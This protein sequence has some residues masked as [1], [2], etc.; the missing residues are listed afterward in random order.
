MLRR[1]VSTLALMILAG[2]ATGE[3]GTQK[4]VL[5]APGFPGT[6]ESAQ[7]VMDRFARAVASRGGIAEG[8]LDALYLNVETDAIEELSRSDVAVAIVPLAFFVAHERDAGLEPWL[9]VARN[10]RGSETWSLVARQGALSAADDLAEWEIASVAGYSPQFVRGPALGSWGPVPPTTRI[11]FSRSLLKD[12]RRAAADEPVALLLDGAQAA[13]MRAL[14]EAA[15]LEV[16]TVSPPLPDVLVCG[17]RG[18][19]SGDLRRGVVDALLS[20]ADAD[21]ELLAEMRLSRFLPLDLA[22]LQRA[23]QLASEVIE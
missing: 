15:Q 4:I 22:A 2:S 23:R 17:V 13:A 6:T 1:I 12:I 3:A 5:C 7:P 18:R 20:L 16:V 21:A 11:T 9:S 19:A 8:A 14:P 10:E